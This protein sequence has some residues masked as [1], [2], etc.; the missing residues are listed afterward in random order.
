MKI[1]AV[2]IDDENRIRR[3]IERLIVSNGNQWDIVFSAGDGQDLVTAYDE[4]PFEFDVLFTDMRMPI[5]DGLNLIKEMKSRTTFN[6]VVISGFDD[7]QYIQASIREGVIDYIM[8]PIDREEFHSQLEKIKH[9]V[10]AQKEEKEQ[11]KWVNEQRNYLLYRQ[12]LEKLK[13]A[14][15]DDTDI[16]LLHELKEFPSGYFQLLKISIDQTVYHKRKLTEDEWKNW[17]L[18]HDNIVLE[19]LRSIQ[20]KNWYWKTDGTNTWILFQSETPAES[21]W[22]DTINEFVKTVQE[23]VQYYTI[24]SHSIA[25]SSTFED[26]LLLTSIKSELSSWMQ[27]RWIYGNNQLFSYEKHPEPKSSLNGEWHKFQQIIEQVLLSLKDVN[28]QKLKKSMSSF[29]EALFLLTDP[30]EMEQ[31]IRAFL[32]QLTHFAIQQQTLTALDSSLLELKQSEELFRTSNLNEIMFEL[33][34]RLNTLLSDLIQLQNHRVYDQITIVKEWV[35]N[36]LGDNITIE[37]LA[38]QVYM[39]PTYFCEYFKAQTGETALD[40]ITRMRISH[41]CELL[42]TTNLKVYEVANSVG[43]S[44]SKYFSKLF[45]K[46]YGEL[47]SKYKTN[48]VAT[49]D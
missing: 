18:A 11:E 5:M 35:R 17:V 28:K 31:V 19:A 16:S 48:M 29:K 36:H 14:T 8:K 43:Y 26:L 37:K 13:E 42:L 47:P 9:K 41:A 27:F 46:Y 32:L 30:K 4:N 3:G 40:Y 39:N 24:F 15:A 25:I 10:K 21:I 20:I 44:D 45:K 1:R 12:Q 7:F 38:R 6:P 49:Q 34:Q 23:Y 22:I 2:I 33:D